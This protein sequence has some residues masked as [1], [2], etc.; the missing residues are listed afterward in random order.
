[1]PLVCILPF[2][3][4]LQALSLSQKTHHAEYPLP[5]GPLSLLGLLQTLP[6]VHVV[7]LAH[8]FAPGKNVRRVPQKL[9]LDRELESHC[10]PGQSKW[11]AKTYKDYKYPTYITLHS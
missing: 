8:V 10:A 7:V 6:S 1:M 2:R 4:G 3:A 9:I 11:I 5:L